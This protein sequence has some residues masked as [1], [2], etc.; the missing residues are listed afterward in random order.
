MILVKQ[1]QKVSY[2]IY[3]IYTTLSVMLS[4]I[5]YASRLSVV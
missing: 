2:M 5:T 3:I 4:D 1:L